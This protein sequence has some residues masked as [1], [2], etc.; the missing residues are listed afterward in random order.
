MRIRPSNKGQDR[1]EKDDRERCI[2]TKGRRCMERRVLKDIF[3]I[4]KMITDVEKSFLIF[5]VS[6]IKKFRSKKSKKRAR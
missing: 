6:I 5:R 2:Y 1:H 4:K 3:V